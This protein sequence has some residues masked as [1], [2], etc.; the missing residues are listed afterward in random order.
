MKEFALYQRIR[1]FSFIFLLLLSYF[2]IKAY[3]QLSTD[4]EAIK[5]FPISSDLSFE[6]G[7]SQIFVSSDGTN[8]YDVIIQAVSQ[9]S[10]KTAVRHDIL[11]LFQDGI[12]IGKSDEWNEDADQLQQQMVMKGR[13]SH[14]FEVISYH[15]AEIHSENELTTQQMMSDDYLY[16]SSTPWDDLEQFTFPA[17]SKQ[18]QWKTII[19]NGYKQLLNFEIEQGIKQYGLPPSEYY[20][21][22]LTRLAPYDQKGLPGFDIST[23]REVIGK[24]WENLYRHYYMGFT[25][26]EGKTIDTTGSTVP[27]IYIEKKGTH[28]IVLFRTKD[29]NF[30]QIF[31]KISG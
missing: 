12:L 4:L 9:T 15:H 28:L 18:K 25:T 20:I 17:S 5:Y 6:S 16:V 21:I 7:N 14:L 13:N 27:M 23:F 11:L 3:D 22:P 8:Q 29:G 30:H 2:G 31:Q 24:L 26:K 10:S 19:D 1:L